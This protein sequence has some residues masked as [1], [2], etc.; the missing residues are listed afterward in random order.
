MEGKQL[1][2]RLYASLFCWHN[3]PLHTPLSHHPLVAFSTLLQPAV[4]HLHVQ[5]EEYRD[6]AARELQEELGVPAAQSSQL[7]QE[8]FIFPY[9]DSTCH[10]FGCLFKLVWEG[11]VHFADAEVESGKWM[12]LPELQQQL[13]EVPEEFT[14]V[15]RHILQLYLEHERQQAA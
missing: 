8:L 14:P 10:V 6:T 2:M 1:V 3:L 13:K 9:Q 11:A 12:A 5:G 4:T 15:G 7:L